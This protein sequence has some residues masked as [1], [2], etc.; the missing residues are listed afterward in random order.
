[1]SAG[2]ALDER[3]RKLHHDLRSPL[4]VIGGFAHLL[5]ADKAIS[6]DDRRQYAEHIE[7]A[8]TE[9]TALI[10]AALSS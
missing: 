5:A 1:V 9:L 7:A 6:D 2:L 4:V 3:L 8:A 10:D